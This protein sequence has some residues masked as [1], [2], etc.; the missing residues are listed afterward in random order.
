MPDA[1]PITADGARSTSSPRRAFV[2]RVAALAAAWPVLGRRLVRLEPSGRHDAA[3]G[4]ATAN[5]DVLASLGDAVLPA[6]LGA[7]GTARAVAEFRRWMDGYRPGA[8]ANH[9]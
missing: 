9:G 4:A 2:T 7:H 3:A 5:A 1:P 6:E 8:E